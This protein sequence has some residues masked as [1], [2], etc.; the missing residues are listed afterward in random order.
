MKLMTIK[1]IA[2]ICNVGIS[3]VSRAI[4]NDPGINPATRERVL[5]VVRQY[6]YVPNNS[7]RNLKIS[8]SKTIALL[9]RGIDNIF[10]QG[11]YQ[12]FQEELEKRGYD[13]FLYSLG[14]NEIIG[15][16]ALE[17]EKEKRLKGIIFLGGTVSD[18]SVEMK[19]LSIPF[20]FC[21]VARQTPSKK[22]PQLPAN[23]AGVAIDDTRE[24]YHLVEY[25]IG[26]GH[27]RIAIIAG[28]KGDRSVGYKRLEG[29]RRA[30]AN[31][32]IEPDP[33]LIVHMRPELPEFSPES[34]YVGAQELLARGTDFTA[35]YCIS[36]LVAMGSYKAFY[37]AGKRI[38]EDYSV[39]GFDGIEIGKYLQPGLTT[40]VQPRREMVRTSVDLMQK[41][42][43]GEDT[44][45]FDIVYPA[46][47]LE[48]QS[49]KALRS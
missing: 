25:L 30:L 9:V 47:L 37:D 49:V 33:D 2:K 39:M 31:H 26:K 21:T 5:A 1:D 38:P 8:E 17:L 41:K 28:K 48:R 44:G 13:F 6:H 15:E 12:L 35:L 22:M 20:V 7:A 45:S 3:T 29:Y 42:L 46:S 4:N 19:D 14:E 36:D 23:G 10:F 40:F 16:A 32:G 27:R 11:M 24:S 43:N 34:G 18:P